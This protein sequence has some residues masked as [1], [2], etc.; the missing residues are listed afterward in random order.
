LG[1]IVRH[2]PLWVWALLAALLM[3]GLS[4]LRARRV[5]PARLL[6][7]P[8]ALLLLGLF[9]TAT[10]F[11][12]PWP[13]LGA[14][15]IALAAGCAFGARLS[16]PAGA[17]WDAHGRTLH[18]P[19]SWLPLLIIVALFGLRYAGGVALV[20]H[21]GWRS[22][23]GVALPIAAAYGAIAGVLLG[24]VLAL[25]RHG[26]TTMLRHAAHRPA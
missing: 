11:M 13:A 4:Q 22:A 16:A 9:S 19:G 6:I 23:P 8:G 15:A 2:T 25:H 26:A 17:A 1:E 3:L 21:P 14:W 18:L 24:R 12:P 5:T 7:L 10:S 20:L